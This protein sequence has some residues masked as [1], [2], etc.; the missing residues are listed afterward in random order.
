ML[1][2]HSANPL[3]T[4]ADVPPSV[5][6]FEVVGVFNAGAC[7]YQDE[8]ILLLRVS[9]RPRQAS[10]DVVLAPHLADDGSLTVK[11]IPLDDPEWDT[12]DPRQVFHLVSGEAYLTSISHLRLARSQDG[13]QFRVEPR[14]WVAP[15][16]PYERFGMEDARIT[17]I[18]D[19]YYVNYTSVSPHGI[20]TSLITTPDFDH[21]RREGMLFPPA[22]RDVTLFPS[23]IRGE[24][25]CYHRPMPGAFGRMSIWMATSPDLRHWGN[26]RVVLEQDAAGWSSGRVGG[27]APPIWTERGWLSVYHAADRDDRY[28][29]GAFLTAHEEPARIIAR[30]DRAILAPQADYETAGFFSNVVFTCGVVV[31]GGVLRVY[32]GAA[33]E[34][35]ALA[36]VSLDDL[37]AALRWDAQT[38]L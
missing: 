17:R 14:P 2:R 13:V 3:L 20:A 16:L 19:T 5:S 1:I 34:C 32:Y 8:I 30:S 6:G 9:E 22:N 10:P 31:Q 11:R 4:P 23:L 35:I 25:V 36:E 27:G 26:H 15:Q 28:H 29:L 7:L 33:D 12:R 18:G 38:R 37:L 21:I 24:Y